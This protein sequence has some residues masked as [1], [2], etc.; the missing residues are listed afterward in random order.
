VET[1]EEFRAYD[2]ALFELLSKV[3]RTHR[4]PMDVFHGKSIRPVRCPA[5]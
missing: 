3:F 5:S 2:P 4:I 1:P